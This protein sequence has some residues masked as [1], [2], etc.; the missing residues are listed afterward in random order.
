MEHI[1]TD[2]L[3]P[4]EDVVSTGAVIQECLIGLT[5]HLLGG[6]EETVRVLVLLVVDLLHLGPVLQAGLVQLTLPSGTHREERE[7]KYQMTPGE[8]HSTDWTEV[9]V[10]APNSFN[11]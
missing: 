11:Y 8:R 1:F 2:G 4:G 6:G 7:E 3:L 10:F 5:G 9:K